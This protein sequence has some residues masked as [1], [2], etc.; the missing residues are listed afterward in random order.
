M[1][2]N[3]FY[4]I[5]SSSKIHVIGHSRKI[6][7]HH[8]RCHDHLLRDHDLLLKMKFVLPSER[9]QRTS[10]PRDSSIK[11][12]SKREQSRTKGKEKT[13]G[14]RYFEARDKDA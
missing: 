13:G 3:E 8:Y 2:K 7:D 11:S 6:E 12:S 1:I 5:V 10:K 9:D 14:R 4:S